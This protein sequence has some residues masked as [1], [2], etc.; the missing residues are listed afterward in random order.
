MATILMND[1]PK[2]KYALLIARLHRDHIEEWAT[3]R[4]AYYEHY[5]WLLLPLLLH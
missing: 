4:T 3:H 1:Y 2:F 5:A